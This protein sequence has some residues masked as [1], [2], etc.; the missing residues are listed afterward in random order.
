[1]SRIINWLLRRTETWKPYVART[2]V[3][4]IDGSMAKGFVMRRWVN[5]RWEYRASSEEEYQEQLAD[6]SIR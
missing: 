2:P 3:T 6:W 5:E 1:M 4:L